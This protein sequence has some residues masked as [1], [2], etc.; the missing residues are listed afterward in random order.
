MPFE[1]IQSL[2]HLWKEKKEKK[3]RNILN[4]G[5]TFPSRAL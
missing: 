2:S 1:V 5:F 3:E 4:P